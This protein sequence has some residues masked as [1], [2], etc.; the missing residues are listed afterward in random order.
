M[1]NFILVHYE[2]V[3]SVH[4]SLTDCSTIPRIACC[5]P[6]HD[7]DCTVKH[8]SSDDTQR[9]P[10]FT[11]RILTNGLLL[12]HCSNS[13]PTH[14]RTQPPLTFNQ[15]HRHHQQQQHLK[16]KSEEKLSS[17]SSP[18]VSSSSSSESNSPSGEKFMSRS[19]YL[20]QQQQQQN[21]SQPR[22][23]TSLKTISI[24]QSS[25]SS[26]SKILYPIDFESNSADQSWYQR[27]S[28]HQSKVHTS[29]SGIVIDTAGTR[30]TSNSS[31][32]EVRL[33]SLITISIN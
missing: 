27:H 3:P 28:S 14:R 31:I 13:N 2:E 25:S 23:A 9:R 8:K 24:P 11:R 33:M 32:E 21:L 20:F 6:L 30:L 16:P 7:E 10:S 4:H 17:L 26:S 29:D 12:S 1:L 19:D 22:K 18:I 15:H 5:V